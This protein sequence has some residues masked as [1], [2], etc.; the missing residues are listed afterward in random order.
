MKA[1]KELTKIATSSKKEMFS[2]KEKT[3]PFSTRNVL[4]RAHFT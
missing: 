4:L 1:A 3:F 2:P